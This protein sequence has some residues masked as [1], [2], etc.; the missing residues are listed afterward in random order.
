MFYVDGVMTKIAERDDLEQMHRGHWP[1]SSE[2][3]IRDKSKGDSFSKGFAVLQT[4]WF[5]SQCIARGVTGLVVTE[6]ELATF[7]FAVLNGILY[8]VWWNKP[9]DVSCPIAIYL[10]HPTSC[11]ALPLD[12][13]RSHADDRLPPERHYSTPFQHSSAFG[14]F[15]ELLKS[16]LFALRYV[17]STTLFHHK[18]D[19]WPTLSMHYDCS[20][21]QKVSVPT[22]YAPLACSENRAR[23]IGLG[24]GVL[25]G[26]IHCVAWSFKFPSVEEQ[27][28]WRISAV[29]VTVIPIIMA[30]L[31]S[32]VIAG[33]SSAIRISLYMSIPCM[34]VYGISRF[35]L[36]VLPLIALRSLPPLSLV[37]FKWSAFIP[38]I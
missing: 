26:G 30:T 38:H 3:D 5:V 14:R 7:A 9:L 1:N 29:N 17:F 35:A 18:I 33:F 25:F 12:E 20:Q 32:F 34:V 27:C 31:V 15:Y 16:P 37:E 21:S 6:L 4:T 13:Q 23:L 22:F 2:K 10:G 24:I 28:I 11:G 36:L 19:N 8:F